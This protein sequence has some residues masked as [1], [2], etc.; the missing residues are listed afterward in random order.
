MKHT[1]REIIETTVEKFNCYY[2]EWEESGFS[3]KYVLG[4]CNAVEALA[5]AL[6]MPVAINGCGYMYIVKDGE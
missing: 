4:K 1:K 6:D 2:A 5:Y 3:N